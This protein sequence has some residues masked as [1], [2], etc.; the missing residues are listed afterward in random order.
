MIRWTALP[1]FLFL[2]ALSGAHAQQIDAKIY[3]K[4]FGAACDRAAA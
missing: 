3:A 2:L 4:I 1:S